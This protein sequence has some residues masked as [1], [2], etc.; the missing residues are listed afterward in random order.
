M[1]RSVA[2]RSGLLLLVLGLALPAAGTPH[3]A[4]AK[5][6]KE[7]KQVASWV[8]LTDKSSL[9]SN[10]ILDYS[11]SFEKKNDNKLT[12]KEKIGKKEKT[13]GSSSLIAKLTQSNH[14]VLNF[15]SSAFHSIKLPPRTNGVIV[16][17]IPE[18]GAALLFAVGTAIVA[19]RLRRM[20]RAA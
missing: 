5:P 6:K 11:S 16:E 14:S 9:S 13:K 1:L 3:D 18:P 8:S 10:W 7:S 17:P 12:S 15:L 19:L 20:P 4:K 2:S